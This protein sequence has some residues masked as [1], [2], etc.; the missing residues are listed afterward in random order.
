MKVNFAYKP[1]GSGHSGPTTLDVMAAARRVI[2]TCCVPLHLWTWNGMETSVQINSRAPG[3]HKWTDTSWT[4][5]MRHTERAR[6]IDA[7]WTPSNLTPKTLHEN[8]AFYAGGTFKFSFAVNG[9]YP[10]DPPKV[11]CLQ[12]VRDSFD[13]TLGKSPTMIASPTNQPTN[14]PPPSYTCG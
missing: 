13:L 12:K 8:I 7:E 14:Q 2:V 4:M 1:C 5:F 3:T 11:K 10:H 6:A 9:N